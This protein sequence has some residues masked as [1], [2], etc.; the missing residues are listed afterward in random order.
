[1]REL[2]EVNT[3]SYDWIDLNQEITF[4][5]AVGAHHGLVVI[6]LLVVLITVSIESAGF[7]IFPSE[8]LHSLGLS[9]GWGSI[10]HLSI[11]FH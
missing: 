11:L 6:L 9:C 8:P 3:V 4:A 2:T 10:E 5:L 1:M 7:I